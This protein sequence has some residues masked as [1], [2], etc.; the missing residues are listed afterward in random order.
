MT[1]RILIVRTSSLG[2]LVH[3]LPAVSDIAAHVTDAR[4]DWVAEESFA[5]IPGWHP[6]VH[7]VIPVAHRRWRRHWWAPQTRRERA[8]LRER[9]GLL[10]NGGVKRVALYGTGE[11]A[12]R[13]E[14]QVRIGGNKREVRFVLGGR[15]RQRSDQVAGIAQRRTRHHG[16]EIDDRQWP[17]IVVEQH[18]GGLGVIVGHAKG[19]SRLARARQFAREVAVPPTAAE[20]V[21]DP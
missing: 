7:E 5:E 6:A 11:A 12:E 18:V 10:S 20:F 17:V 13:G 8:A 3:L 21:R 16:V 9:L 4:I 15:A 14:H 1:T 2:D 19:N